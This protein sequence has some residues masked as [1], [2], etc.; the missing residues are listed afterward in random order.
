MHK[1]TVQI[2][3]RAG[4]RKSSLQASDKYLQ[5]QGTYR[6]IHRQKM[7]MVNAS[8]MNSSSSSGKSCPTW[9]F[10]GFYVI[11]FIVTATTIA[12][13][14]SEFPLFPFQA[15]SLEWNSN[16]LI[17]TVIDYYG[18][19]LCFCGIV[20]KSEDN[21][22]IGSLWC[23]GCCLLG[24]PICCVWMLIFLWK[25]GADSLSLSPNRRSHQQLH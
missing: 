20:F 19:C 9:L 23:L 12:K 4:S 7:T 13:T 8:G 21:W 18:A 11:L 22:I 25:H 14:A 3:V 5:T 10:I 6:R 24:S 16:W 1:N 15:D 17:A 2:C